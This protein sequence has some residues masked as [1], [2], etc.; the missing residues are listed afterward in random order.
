MQKTQELEFLESQIEG[1][2]LLQKQEALKLRKGSASLRISLLKRMLDWI[3]IN[4]EDIRKA[5]HADYQKPYPEIDV[6]EIFPVLIE[7]N[8]A[9]KHLEH[10]MKPKKV[11]TPLI[12]LGTKAYI[13]Y[14]PKG[15][16]L[17]LAPWNYAFNLAVG[18]LV[19]AIAAGCPTFVKPS[20]MTP[21]TSA[22]LR[23]MIAEIF[24]SHTVAVIEGGVEVSQILLSKPFDH[25]FF[26]GS[27]GVGKIVMKAAAEHLASVTLELGGK[28]PVLILDDADLKD[29][30][31]KITATKFLNCGQTCIAPDYILI[32][33]RLKDA[34]VGEM[35]KSI[36]K[37]YDSNKNGIE[38]SKDYSRIVNESHF[39][40]IQ[41]ILSDANLKG[42][43]IEFGGNSNGQENY[44]EPTIL[45]N[46]TWEMKVL[47]E[48]IF[49][50]ILPVVTYDNLDAAIL[51]VNQQPKPLAFYVFS[52]NDEKINTIFN[53]TSSGAALAND[54]AVHFLHR[55]LPFGGVN[56]SG[57]GKSHGHF[58]FLAFSNEKAVL[59]QR[60]GSAA[61]NPLFPPFT[62]VKK[63]LV[64]GILKWL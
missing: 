19:S 31:D 12:F 32:P 23:R 35:K 49:G 17:I 62:L 13:Q 27:P 46:V 53:E 3:N 40:R 50:P 4:Q 16:S 15:V 2:F 21:H 51:M 37:M 47:Q 61:V 7:I 43:K 59:K 45:S 33:E 38:G 29:T 60:V 14:E 10:W 56:N 26:T 64:K 6:T 22:L 48:E 57:I 39:K 28:S 52:K 1:I 30:A 63:K 25:I 54:C 44:I 55:E 20:E 36:E 11:G 42:A 24:D 5:V 34:F 58:G 41:H 9:I 18:P 8:H